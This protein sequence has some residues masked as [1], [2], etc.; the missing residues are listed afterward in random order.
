MARELTKIVACPNCKKSVPWTEQSKHRPFCSARCRLIDLGAWASEEHYI[1][2]DPD[3][4]G[5]SEN[6]ER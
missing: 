3:F 6:D 1:A 5:S 2:G 4:D